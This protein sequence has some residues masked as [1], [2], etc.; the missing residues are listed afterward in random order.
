MNSRSTAFATPR[1]FF[2]TGSGCSLSGKYDM[3][4]VEQVEVIKG[5]ISVLYGRLEPGGMVN[6]VTKKPL[7]QPMYA[8]EQQVGS[9]NMLR[10]IVDAT[11]PI[12]EA[13]TLLYRIDAGYEDSES[14]RQFVDADRRI[15]APS[16][17][18]KIGA[19]TELLVQYEYFDNHST[20]DNI[21]GIAFGDRPL[22]LPDSRNL[23]E[24]TDFIDAEKHSTSATLTH[25][26]SSEWRGDLRFDYIDNHE[27]DGGAYGD[28]VDDSAILA[29]LLPRTIEGSQIGLGETVDQTAYSTALNLTGRFDALGARHT[30]LVGAD[31]RSV[32]TDSV[33]CGIRGQLLSD[34][35]IFQPVHRVTVG[36]VEFVDYSGS[37]REQWQGYY[38]QDQLELPGQVHVLLGVR[39][40]VIDNRDRLNHTPSGDD[41]A[42]PP[43]GWN[44]APITG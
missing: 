28:Y 33:C 31:Y 19:D 1:R 42:T 8:I 23:A 32:D 11:G 21:G 40:D 7:S 34:I 10:T 13:G 16:L 24:R 44:E 5:P 2:A 27:K 18:W 25:A 4:N 36:P 43:R 15:A 41:G 35:S 20:P 9:F 17:L 3:T 6:Y 39:Y 26:F 14:F 12:D 22:D 29:D 38:A 30:V 37:N